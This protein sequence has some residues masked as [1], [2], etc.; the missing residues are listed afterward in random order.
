MSFYFLTEFLKYFF[1]V[2]HE[3]S[4]SW[5]KYL[6][7]FQ[8]R[9]CGDSI[10]NAPLV[11]LQSKNTKTQT[12]RLGLTSDSWCVHN[13]LFNANFE[14]KFK[15]TL[16]IFIFYIFWTNQFNLLLLKFCLRSEYDVKRKFVICRGRLDHEKI[17]CFEPCKDNL[18]CFITD[19]IKADMRRRECVG[20]PPLFLVH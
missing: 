9:I 7:N 3:A 15:W 2:L 17:L 11:R 1:R 12:V 6:H 5:L 4:S 16:D 18:K 19:V 13:R 14:D 20:G 8:N 10:V